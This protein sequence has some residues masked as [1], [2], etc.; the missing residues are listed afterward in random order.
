MK[1]DAP[2]FPL[3][4]T[5]VERRENIQNI[6]ESDMVVVCGDSV[7]IAVPAPGL[8]SLGVNSLHLRDQSCRSRQNG[9]HFVLTSSLKSCGSNTHTD[10]RSSVI[11]NTVCSN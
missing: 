5:D 2:K 1:F 9:T 4:L 8:V 11:S 3:C 7:E 6:L 10:G